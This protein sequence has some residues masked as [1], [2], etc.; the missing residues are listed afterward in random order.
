MNDWSVSGPQSVKV[1]FVW[2]E[3]SD[4]EKDPWVQMAETEKKTHAE[5]Y[6]GY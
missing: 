4:E 6:P 1:G 3:M 5:T 2:R